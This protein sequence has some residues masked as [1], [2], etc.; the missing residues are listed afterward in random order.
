K[1]GGEGLMLHHEAAYYRDGDSTQLLKLK[2]RATD[3]AKVIA[4]LPG[5]GR[6]AGRLGALLVER[7]DGLRFRIGS[8]FSDAERAAPPPP[9]S[10]IVYEHN[11]YTDSGLPRFARYLHVA[12]D[13]KKTPGSG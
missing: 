6:N 10:W 5:A 2:P 1:A 11:G 7:A 9:G 4:H 8:G 3:R 13:Q 12:A